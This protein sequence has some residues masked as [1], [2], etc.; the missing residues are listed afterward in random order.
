MLRAVFLL[1]AMSGAASGCSG[2]C[3]LLSSPEGTR[4]PFQANTVVVCHLLSHAQS[5]NSLLAG[6]GRGHHKS[7][8]DFVELRD[9]PNRKS[10]C[11]E[12]IAKSMSFP[13]FTLAVT[14]VETERL[15]NH[16][17]RSTFGF[18]TADRALH[19][20]RYLNPRQSAGFNP[21]SAGW[22]F[23]LCQQHLCRAE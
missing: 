23:C 9:R 19:N 20:L 17:R 5:M 16:W 14:V 6:R 7:I 21:K 15:G 1:S 2:Q 11:I 12:C 4:I 22:Q 10:V 3:R 18:D 13:L 8:L